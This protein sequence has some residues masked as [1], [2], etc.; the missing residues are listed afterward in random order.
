MPGYRDY[1]R[2]RVAGAP[3]DDCA[4]CLEAFVHTL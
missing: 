2:N 4:R 1:E 3:G